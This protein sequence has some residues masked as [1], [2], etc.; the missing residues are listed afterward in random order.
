MKKLILFC[1]IL[2]GTLNN[3][4]AQNASL[5]KQQTLDYIEKLYKASFRHTPDI[6]FVVT[7]VTLDNKTLQVKHSNGIIYRTP[8]EDARLLKVSFIEDLGYLVSYEASTK[9]KDTIFF[10][11]QNESDANKLI[12]ALNHLIAILKTEKNTDPFGN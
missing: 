4:Q 7:S 6:T 2:L 3:T 5:N 12:K 9:L 11:V 1:I 8:L 10:S